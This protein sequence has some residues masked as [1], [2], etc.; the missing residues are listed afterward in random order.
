MGSDL[1]MFSG[2]DD[3]KTLV[4][5]NKIGESPLTNK[6]DI[7][8]AQEKFTQMKHPLYF[9]QMICKFK[10]LKYILNTFKTKLIIWDAS[11]KKDYINVTPFM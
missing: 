8:M 1:F 4:F 6:Q 10:T 3:M 5:Q 7:L 11:L 2:G 9:L